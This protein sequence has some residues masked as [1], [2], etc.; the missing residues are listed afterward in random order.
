MVS[1][2]D[3]KRPAPRPASS[4]LACIFSERFGLAPLERW[5]KALEKFLLQ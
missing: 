2:D 3:L 5:E 1:K 4:K